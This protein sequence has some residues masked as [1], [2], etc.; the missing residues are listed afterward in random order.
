MGQRYAHPGLHG[1]ILTKLSL[2][3]MMM[4][5]CS[6]RLNMAWKTDHFRRDAVVGSPLPAIGNSDTPFVGAG[7]GVVN[8]RRMPL[9][10]SPQKAPR[11]GGR[12]AKWHCAQTEARHLSPAV[13]VR[14]H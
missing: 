5:S 14:C 10:L 1:P 2:D 13:L 6:A 7:A 8:R 12:D 3:S 11:G 4:K 9:D